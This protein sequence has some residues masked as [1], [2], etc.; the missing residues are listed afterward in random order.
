MPVCAGNP[1]TDAFNSACC[2]PSKAGGP[3]LSSKTSAAG[4]PSAKAA[5][6]R[7]MVCG[8]PSPTPRPPFQQRADLLHTQ[9]QPPLG[10]PN[11][12]TQSHSTLMRVS[13]WLRF[14]SS[15]E[16]QQVRNNLQR[17]YHPER[18]TGPSPPVPAE[19]K[20]GTGLDHRPIPSPH[21]QQEQ[22]YQRPQQLS[23]RTRPAE[24]HHRPD[25]THHHRQREDDGDSS[26]TAKSFSNLLLPITDASVNLYC[27]LE[28]GGWPRFRLLVGYAHQEY[29]RA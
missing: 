20:A 1:C 11:C 16:P 27:S 26:R 4:P 21:R 10:F 6:H 23:R 9:Q 24:V 22:D 28:I 8:D 19:F 17:Q 5:A 7:P 13:P 3:P 29:T 15:P 25:Q 12:L 2:S 18:Y 14:R